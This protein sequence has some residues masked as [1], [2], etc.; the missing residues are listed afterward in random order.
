[1]LS[2]PAKLN[3]PISKTSSERL[4]LTIQ[5][6]RIENKKLK[7]KVMELQQELWKSSLKVSLYHPMIIRFCLSLATR[8]ASAYDDIRYD[9]K[10]GT[11]ILI[12]PSRRRLRDYKN[13]IR[14][15]TG[16]NKNIINELKN[17]TKNF[18]D[19]EKF[20][21]I[22]MD[23]MKIQSNLVWDK[24]TGELIGY[25]D[26]GDTELNYATLEKNW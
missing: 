24:H 6:F 12:L 11:S 9:E 25:V 3:A 13:Y 8:S 20:F 16:F 21:V 22:L 17:K 7:E 26:L 14:P 15:E 5:S 23:E 2:T 19:K 4:K 18:S 1:M 10:S